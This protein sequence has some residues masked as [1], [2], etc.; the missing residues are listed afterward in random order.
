MF[1]ESEREKDE[2][3]N[4]ISRSVSSSLGFLISDSAI[5]KHS[6]MLLSDK[7]EDENGS[8]QES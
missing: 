2:W 4:A 5:T 6:S 8:D 1:A 3:I 7:E